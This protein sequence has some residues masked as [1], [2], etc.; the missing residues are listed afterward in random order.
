MT[1]PTVTQA[2]QT[3]ARPA[4]SPSGTGVAV[5]PALEILGLQKCFTTP[6]GERRMVVDVPAFTLA[7]GAEQ[8]LWGQSGSGK[9]SFLHLIAGLLV[10]DAGRITVA[11]QPMSGLRESARD[12]RRASTIGCV[13]QSFNLLP[14]CTCLENV[15]LGM[16][17]GAGPD[18][19][20]AHALLE[21]VGLGA[22]A[23]HFP[24][25]LSSGQQQRVAIARALANR[26][27]LVLAD[28]PTGALDPQNARAALALIRD[29]CREAGAALLLVSH[30]RDVLAQFE[31][32]Q[33]FAALNHAARRDAP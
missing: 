15:L 13:Y 31:R 8:A 33:S 25:Q 11:G 9:T 26:P 1:S 29:T 17:F 30:D 6:E 4:S 18:P 12:R 19:A 5:P 27:Q 20:R 32:V 7:K 21:R 14:G 23:G 22:K 28:E 10:P 24:R 16:A 2:N 3:A